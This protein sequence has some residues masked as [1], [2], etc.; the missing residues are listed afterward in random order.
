MSDALKITEQSPPSDL[1]PFIES[2]WRIDNPHDQDEDVVT[3]PD[4]GIDLYFFQNAECPLHISLVGLETQTQVASMPKRSS[5]L[6]VRLK[7]LAAEYLLHRPIAE[8]LNTRT[9]LDNGYA[10]ITPETFKSFTAFCQTLTEHFEVQLTQ[11]SLVDPRKMAMSEAIYL[12]HGNVSVSEIAD[13]AS[14]SSRQI[15][16]YFNKWLGLPMKSYCDILRFRHSFDT[17][18]A[19]ELYPSEGFNDQSHYIKLIKKYSSLTPKQLARDESDRFIQLLT[20]K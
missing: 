7:L 10:Q 12:A 4:G 15:N 17:L 9:T 14:W 6:G 19:G 8:L 16:R 5:L 1:A 3:F 20:Q 11:T 18:K 13:H 2:F